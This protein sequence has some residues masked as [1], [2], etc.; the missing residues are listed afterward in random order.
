MRIYVA[1]VNGGDGSYSI[2]FYNSREA[3]ELLY[4]NDCEN[5]GCN[6]SFSS[7]ELEGTIT[8]ISI[9]TIED[10]R[11]YLYNMGYLDED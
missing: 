4:D 10:A 2:E 5:Y 9:L 1:T 3:I 6:E 11:E 7:F 8:G